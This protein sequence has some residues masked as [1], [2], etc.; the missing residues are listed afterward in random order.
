M[1]RSSLLLTVTLAA[2]LVA[3]LPASELDALERS[4]VELHKR[5]AEL[6]HRL[7]A[8]EQAATVR[9]TPPNN[10]VVDGP[11]LN[12]RV[13]A[14]RVRVRRTDQMVGAVDEDLGALEEHVD[15]H[16]S[17]LEVLEAAVQELREVTNSHADSIDLLADQID[18]WHDDMDFVADLR[19][20]VLVEDGRVVIRDANLLLLQGRRPEDG[21]PAANGMIITELSP[22][23]ESPR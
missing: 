8:Q 6:E 20:V 9:T 11:A 12:E 5:T 14:M 2:Q 1:H 13:R 16:M 4:L 18:A 10:A 15:R 22:E 23:P 3:C 17:R 7:E 19:G 21:W